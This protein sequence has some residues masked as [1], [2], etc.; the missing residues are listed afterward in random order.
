M[1]WRTPCLVAAILFCTLPFPV[2]HAQD[3]DFTL[4]FATLA[5]LIPQTVGTC[6]ENAVYNPVNGDGLQA[7]TTGLLVWR[8]ADNFTAFTDGYRSWVNGPLG[9]QERLNTERFSWEWNPDRLPII[10]PPVPDDRCHTAG[11]SLGTSTPEGFA[12]GGTVTFH[13]TNDLAVPCTMDG[14]VGA[15]L[16]GAANNALP[17]TV[18]R[19]GTAGLG[20]P[21]PGPVLRTLPP[22]GTA[23]FLM[24]WADVP[25]SPGSCPV[26]SRIAVTPPDEYAPIIIPVQI[27]PCGGLVRITAV[28]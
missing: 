14:Y 18:A 6:L 15:Q 23:D 28:L 20:E 11:L 1:R 5:G 7:T 25:Y 2:A 24:G 16:L 17:T 21:D 19:G 9:L 3:C 22:G 27:G 10:P 13:F 26:A 8:K 12:G 4:G